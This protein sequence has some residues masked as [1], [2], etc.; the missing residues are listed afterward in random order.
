MPWACGHLCEDGVLRYLLYGVSC[1]RDAFDGESVP[2]IVLLHAYEVALGVDTGY[3]RGAGTHTGIE[4]G[5]PGSV[6]VLIR[7]SQR[8]TGFC[9][10]CESP[11]HLCSWGM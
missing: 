2:M 3:A 5:V 6:Y 11:V 8:A 4:D 10:G 7:Y 9:V 1:V